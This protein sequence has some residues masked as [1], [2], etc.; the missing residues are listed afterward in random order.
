MQKI[1]KENGFTVP[2]ILLFLLVLGFVGGAGYYVYNQNSSK[3]STNSQE[4]QTETKKESTLPTDLTGLKTADEIRTIA[5]ADLGTATIVSVELEQEDG[6]LVYKVK[7]SDGKIL[8][9]D[10]KTGTATT[11]EKVKDDGV[12]NEAGDDDSASIPSGFVAGITVDQAKAKAMA[13]LPGKTVKKVEL[14]PEDGVMVYSVRFTDGSRVDVNATSGAVVRTENKS[15]PAS[16][17]TTP[18]VSN[19]SDDSDD[20]ND[21]SGGSGG[22]SGSGS[23][24]N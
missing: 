10:A 15:A 8:F 2:H 11:K 13:T 17:T 14:E 19:D 1:N 22:N 23:G 4:T 6:G 16:T 3:S 20:T 18:S 24:H 9:F 12:E 7:L 21:D 5:G